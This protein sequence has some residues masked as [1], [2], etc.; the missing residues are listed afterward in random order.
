VKVQGEVL[1]VL[2]NFFHTKEI[3]VILRQIMIHTST[4]FF[5]W[6]IFTFLFFSV[7][8]NGTI[9]TFCIV[10]TVKLEVI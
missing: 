7:R 2:H 1:D 8:C 5:R 9:A 4:H 3:F 10:E 6:G